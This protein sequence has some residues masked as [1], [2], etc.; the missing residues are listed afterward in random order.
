[1]LFYNYQ[2]VCFIDI[3]LLIHVVYLLRLILKFQIDV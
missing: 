1:M 2:N 3:N